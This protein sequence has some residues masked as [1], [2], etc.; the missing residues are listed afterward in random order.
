[1]QPFIHH[2][3]INSWTCQ[4]LLKIVTGAG[5]QERTVKS[6]FYIFNVEKSI[7]TESS[8]RNCH[9]ILL[10]ADVWRQIWGNNQHSYTLTAA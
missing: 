7:S 1:M 8:K 5:T 4:F 10:S 9:A 6:F 3:V 2:A